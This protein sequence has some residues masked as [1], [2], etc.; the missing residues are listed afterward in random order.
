MLGGYDVWVPGAP[1]IALYKGAE[2][3]YRELVSAW[4]RE[5]GLR[6]GSLVDLHLHVVPGDVLPDLNRLAR[7]VEEAAEVEVR[8]VEVVRD[9]RQGVG[10]IWVGKSTRIRRAE[11]LTLF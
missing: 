10:L 6:P 5:E 11:Q 2:R 8:S 7:L 9:G 3:D 4:C 1:S